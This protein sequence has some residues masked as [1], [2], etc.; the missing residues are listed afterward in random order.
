MP[1]RQRADTGGDGYSYYWH[2]DGRLKM[3]SVL[4]HNVERVYTATTTPMVNAV[5]LIGL[6][7]FEPRG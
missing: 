7:K 1:E 5:P 6:V 4:C 3:L 2:C